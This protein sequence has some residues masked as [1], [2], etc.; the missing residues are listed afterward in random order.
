MERHDQDKEALRVACQK[1]ETIAMGFS[2]IKDGDLAIE[3]V[4]NIL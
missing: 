2:P 3:F 1:I 4:A